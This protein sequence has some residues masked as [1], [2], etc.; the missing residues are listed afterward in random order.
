[1]HPNSPPGENTRDIYEISPRFRQTMEERIV[2]LERDA[3]EDER[4]LAVL[5]HPDHIRRHIRLIAVQRAEALRLRLFLDQ[6]RTRMPRPLIA[7][8]SE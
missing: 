8:E 1:M 4:T 6:A 5:N 3:I 2:R 7:L